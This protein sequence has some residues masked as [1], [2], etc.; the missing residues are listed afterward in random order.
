MIKI[1]SAKENGDYKARVET[2]KYGDVLMMCSNGYQFT[3]VPTTPKLA[4]L[5]IEVLQEYLEGFEDAS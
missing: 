5:T 1:I 2:D 3:G 4:K